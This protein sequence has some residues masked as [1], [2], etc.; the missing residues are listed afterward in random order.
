LKSILAY[1]FTHD[2]SPFG[3]K[4]WFDNPFKPCESEARH[5]LS[6]WGRE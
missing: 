5:F 2:V 4:V 6:R 3:L 1:R